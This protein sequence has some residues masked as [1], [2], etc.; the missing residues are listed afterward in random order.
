MDLQLTLLGPPRLTTDPEPAAVPRL[1]AKPI[2]LLAF[3]AMEPGPHSR[4]ELA[5]LLWTDSPNDAA[6]ASL[7]QAIRQIRGV[8]GERLR[9]GRTAVELDP[10]IPC[11]ARA[12]L[13][14]VREAPETAV[15]YAAD[16]F[17]SGFSVRHAPAFEEWTDTTRERLRQ[18]FR[19]ALRAATL[20]DIARSHWRDAARW[21]EQWIAADPLSDEA[22]RHAAEAFY[23]AGDTGEALAQFQQYRERLAD[24]TGME[25]A[26][27]LRELLDRIRHTHAPTPTPAPPVA[28]LADP[29]PDTNFPERG[30]ASGLIGREAEW[31]RLTE[32]WREAAAG[33]CRTLL[34][35]G[36]AG[37][38]KTRLA[39][40]LLQW[41]VAEGA[42]ALRGRGY[43]PESGLPYQP[44]ADALRGALQA[45][46]MASTSPEWLAEL[47]RIVP[48]VRER[49]P[50]IPTGAGAGDPD[51]RGRLFE[52]VAQAILG[53]TSER[54]VVLLIDDLQRCDPETCAL[55]HFLTRRLAPA[56]I[57][58]LATA[59]LGEIER[60]TPA[61]R[62]CRTL[63]SGE[64]EAGRSGAAIT[65]SPLSEAQVWR[66]IRELGRIS[67]PDGARRFAHRVHTVTDGNPFHIIE[68][69]KALFAQGMLRTDP[70][71][72]EWVAT[73]ATGDGPY[74]HVRMPATVHDAIA[75]RCARLPYE[76]RDLLVTIAV[77]G[78][79]VSTG[80]LSHVHGTSRLRAAA[81]A[82]ALVDRLLLAED[83]DLYGCA[84]P[85]VQ[86]VVREDLTP[87]RKGE[88]HRAIALA[89]EALGHDSR[90]GWRPGEIA[91]H[92]ERGGEL[93][94]A[95]RYALE[96]SDLA[97]EDGTYDEALSWLDLAGSAADSETDTA[98]V[99]E[100][101]ARLMERTGWPEPPVRRSGTPAAG[102]SS[103]DIDLRPS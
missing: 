14:A 27:A 25:P 47:A 74:D 71:T 9:A 40:E 39:E 56:P 81:L 60:A 33:A 96:A 64:G 18:A 99:H 103:Q 102:F 95:F 58:I 28:Q 6:R 16:R 89:L 51:R 85:I 83:D 38:G 13:Q 34:I 45:P 36:E 59:T 73:T 88:V 77:A 43:D 90:A 92:A 78:R 12:F 52:A 24:E 42:T 32:V 22:V 31:E 79:P 98:A 67:S 11:D 84:H 93:A 97:V 50:S 48:D 53:L 19:D 54:A 87:G 44:V 20:G 66:T 15:S 17:L 72:G 4:D 1:G 8:V 65:V 75:E 7:R 55:L 57:L 29:P 30:F 23:M 63:K 41:V 26:E 69:L 70:D 100:R 80:L 3:L 10:P 62:L 61:S 37:I 94:L 5:G 35:Q 91:R 82:D 76:L 68:L 86:D 46:G 21:A 101:T 49:F 2:A